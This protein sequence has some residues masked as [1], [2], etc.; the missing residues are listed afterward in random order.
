MGR[1]IVQLSSKK[2]KDLYL[3]KRLSTQRIANICGCSQV[4]II[5]RLREWGVERRS[6]TQMGVRYV[7]RP[8]DGS[9]ME[10]AYLIGFRIGDL[11]VYKPPA[12]GS[13]ILVVRCHTTNYEQAQL[14]RDLFKRYG[15]VRI[16]SSSYNGF[17]VN[18]FVDNSFS[19]LKGKNFPAW[20]LRKGRWM[21]GFIAGY[22]DAEGYFGLNQGRG[23]F[24]IDSC[25]YVILKQCYSFLVQKR[26]AATFYRIA[27]KG[28]QNHNGEVWNNDL[29]R[30][31]INK[32]LSLKKF[33]SMI[34]PF[35]RHKKRKRDATM[36]LKDIKKRENAG[37]I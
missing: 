6:K 2:V 13:A 18:C 9:F 8:F 37:T 10:K 14:I 28:K 30:L 21:A 15:G 16:A 5:N 26:V 4:T 11:N 12:R 19:F 17:T 25:D 34:A 24:K 29:W 32:A 1:S 3:K 35:L 31:Q 7:K 23:R 22:T 36:V 33:L 27:E 20:V